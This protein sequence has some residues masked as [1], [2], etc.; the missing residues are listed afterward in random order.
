MKVLATKS[1]CRAAVAA[2]LLMHAPAWSQTADGEKQS[3]EEVRNTVI[4]LLQALVQKGVMTKEQAEAMVADA[5]AK[6][7]ADATARAAKDAAESD[8]VRVTYVP[9]TVRKQ[10]TA[11]VREDV[12]AEVTKEVM[13][14]AK[15]E[16]WGVP[17]A[18]PG[19]IKNVKLYGDV[20]ARTQGDE[21]ADD[22]A[23]NVYRDFQAIND[24]GGIAAAGVDRALLNTTVDRQRLVGRVRTG[25]TADLGSSF[26]LDVRLASGNQRSPVSTN[27]TLGN[28]GGRWEVNVDKAAI[29]WN[30]ISSDRFQEFDL[31]AGRFGNPFV[32]FNELLWDNDLTFEGISASYAL[33]LFGNNP[34]R[35]E[36][37]LFFTAGAFPL[38]E[39][40]LS[41][42]DKWLYGGQL[43]AEFTF[44]E[45]MRLRFASGYFTYKN[46]TGIRNGPTGTYF[47]YTAPVFMQKGNT[48]FDIR[49]DTDND[50]QLYALA[51]KYEIA[52]ASLVLDMGFG[53]THVTI[54]G[55]Y[56]KNLGWESEDVL[57]RTGSL[58]D[59]RT[60]GYEFGVTV[61]RPSISALW[62][63]RAFM[64]YR[65]VERDA[66]LD[67][68]TDSDFHLGGTDA[69]GYQLGFDL[70]LSRGAWLRLR[71]LT[72]N[73]IDGPPLGIDVWQL[74]L[75]G[76]F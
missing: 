28:Y 10:I 30:P 34:D 40:S 68:F 55:E 49:N 26:A 39:L 63:W 22:N 43:G 36:R 58:L 61:G 6:A 54:G 18:L 73:E 70:G 59:E 65:Y 57:Q 4:N 62:N 32:G 71:Y 27:Q 72:A 24:A 31:R 37:G 50:T 47:D 13:A 38:Q 9:E 35:M 52:N 21:Y 15:T 12:K 25:F 75:N 17:G 7:T 60:E 74:D 29:L 16:G 66:V 76:A 20:R 42:D 8:A 14:Q 33:D 69:K 45:Q 2:T 23:T 41:S 44:G 3:L 64:S 1:L 46:I 56:V 19:W 5:Q 51:G 11:E 48:V 67:A 53:D